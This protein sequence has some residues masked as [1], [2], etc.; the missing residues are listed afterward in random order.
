VEPVAKPRSRSFE[1]AHSHSRR[2]PQLGDSGDKDVV[3]RYPGVTYEP[4]P[5][6]PSH[7]RAVGNNRPMMEGGIKMT[8]DELFHHEQRGIG[9][10]GIVGTFLLTTDCKVLDRFGRVVG[11]LSDLRIG[12]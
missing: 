11:S 3:P 2:R 9:G 10:P 7:T 4:C 6:H 12:V 8:G 1:R 5:F